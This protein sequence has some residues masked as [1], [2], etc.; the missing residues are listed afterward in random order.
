MGPDVSIQESDGER[1]RSNQRNVMS[2]VLYLGLL[3]TTYIGVANEY[4]NHQTVPWMT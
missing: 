3:R 4:A 2:T 1:D